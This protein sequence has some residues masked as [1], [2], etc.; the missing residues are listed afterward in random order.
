MSDQKKRYLIKAAYKPSTITSYYQAFTRFLCWC[1]DHQEDPPTLELLDEAFV[2]WLHDLYE[3]YGSTGAGKTVGIKARQGLVLALPEAKGHL[4]RTTLA[5]KGWMKEAPTVSYPPLTWPL[6]CLVACR[7]IRDGHMRAGVG[8]LLAH[9]CLLRNGELTSL[10]ASDIADVKDARLGNIPVKMHLAL[11][12]TKTGRNQ[13]VQVLNDDVQSLVR[14][15]LEKTRPN[16]KVFPYTT[17]QFRALFKGACAALQL[18]PR[19][20]PHSLRHGATTTLHLCKWSL[21]DIMLR[22]RWKSS[23]S[24]RTYIQSG[25]A[26]LLQMQVPSAVAELANMFAENLLM[27]VALAQMH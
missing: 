6:A 13:F 22:G 25:T 26:L 7:L 14:M 12:Q 5:L 15:L 8:V 24:A 4:P 1:R 23:A 10:K 20:V 9:D 18:S 3:E 27:A 17:D 16:D 19:Y 11:R 2:D 21:E